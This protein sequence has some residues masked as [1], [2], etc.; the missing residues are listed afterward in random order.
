MIEVHYIDKQE[1]PDLYPELLVLWLNYVINAEGFV[2][3]D[4]N[5]IFC[6]DDHLL[7]VNKTYLDHDYYTDIVTFDYSDSVVLCG[8][9]FI[10]LDRVL[11]N[12]LHYGDSFLT[13]LRRVCVHG[14]LHLCGYR[15]KTLQE[16]SEMRSKEQI[17][18][19]EY[20]SRET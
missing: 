13:E 11:D 14:V 15:D 6:S 18:L 7:E 19:N 5:L 20:V 1:V 17:Y 8:D 16:V 12:A 3:G 9:L 10:S 2:C 4:V